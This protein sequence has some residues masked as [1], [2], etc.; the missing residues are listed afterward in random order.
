MNVY[1][2]SYTEIDEVDLTKCEDHRDFGRGFYVTKFR[3]QAEEWAEK[4]A[5]KHQT[6]PVI[7]EFIFYESA[8]NSWKYKVLRF[9]GYSSEWFDFVILNRNPEFAEPMHDYDIIEGPVADDRVQRN[10]DAFLEGRISR[11]KFLEMLRFPHYETHQIC[12]CSSRSLLM[13]KPRNGELIFNIEEIGELVIG[14]LVVD[15]GFNEENAADM[16]F[17]S[18]VFGKL[19]EKST[20][21][22]HKDWQEIYRILKQ[23]L[24]L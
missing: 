19:S 1:H 21:F 16:F 18:A 10:I 5:A 24:N 4:I 15:F 7:T 23:E 6:T 17:S 14:Q 2:G 3:S 13:L 11:E 9:D 20:G 12:F 22:C 8:F